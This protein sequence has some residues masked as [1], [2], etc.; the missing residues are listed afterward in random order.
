MDDGLRLP[1]PLGRQASGRRLQTVCEG[2]TP[3][4]GLA[5]AHLTAGARDQR[6]PDD[7]FDLVKSSEDGSW[8]LHQLVL[9]GRE[10]GEAGLLVDPAPQRVEQRLLVRE[11]AVDGALL[12]ASHAGDL[13]GPERVVGILLEQ[14]RR[15]PQQQFP[16]P[17]G[18]RLAQRAV[19]TF[20]C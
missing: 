7:A 20:Q 15:S 3:L 13:A 6:G 11:V 10:R 4:D 12:D 8:L 18:L 16:R 14:R 5:Q 1:D 19:I 9:V 2:L 17:L